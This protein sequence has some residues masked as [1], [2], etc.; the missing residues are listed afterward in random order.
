MKPFKTISLVDR[1]KASSYND[2][3]ARPTTEVAQGEINLKN[4]TEGRSATEIELKVIP[5][6][7]RRN[8][9][10]LK[11]LQKSRPANELPTLGKFTTPSLTSFV[12]PTAGIKFGQTMQLED[13]LKQSAKVENTAHLP[14][15]YLSDV[16][17]NYIKIKPTSIFE[18]TS[19]V[20]VPKFN[21]IANKGGTSISAWQFNSLQNQGVVVT[22]GNYLS[23][24]NIK[25]PT[26]NVLVSQGTFFTN[27]RF[28]SQATISQPITQDAIL[29][30]QG[31]VFS[32]GGY[33]SITVLTEPSINQNQG[34]L[35]P[36]LAISPL[37]VRLAQGLTLDNAGNL[38]SY[39]KP[40][41]PI[42]L[43]NPET[44][45]PT[46][47]Q[48]SFSSLIFEQG[49]VVLV[50]VKFSTTQVDQGTIQLQTSQYLANR[51]KSI[52]LPRIEHGSAFLPVT[53]FQNR[54]FF[55]QTLLKAQGEDWFATNRLNIGESPVT[56]LLTNQLNDAQA[57]ELLRGAITGWRYE[58]TNSRQGAA[59][60]GN[61][62]VVD[63]SIPSVWNADVTSTRPGVVERRVL[64]VRPNAENDQSDFITFQID[65]V[66]GGSIKFKALITSLTDNWSPSWS[67]QNYVG[68]QDTLKVFKGVTRSVSLSFKVVAWSNAT[69][70]FQKLETL[71]KI[72]SVGSP[73]GPG[74]VKGPLI[75]LT[76]GKLFDKVYCA[77]NSLK[78]DFN[79]AEF[80]WD[81][82]KQLPMLAD[83][84]MDVAILTSNNAQMFNAD[85]NRYFNY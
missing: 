70:M 2:I 11:A 77:C 47:Q 43:P 12:L 84:S 81:I 76:V 3:S 79:P 61:V 51:A 30:G 64:G 22:N 45:T 1:L 34:G 46:L 28:I 65:K 66:S 50:N 6:N 68:R 32:N 83:V 13:R 8:E 42:E 5:D 82:K 38:I 73:T 53:D 14:H 27:G 17:T 80:S 39:T 16:Y 36:V 35:A 63:Q 69:T 37:V 58:K 75:K 7:R 15:F 72:T 54:N 24:T 20:E 4:T 49:S 71:A 55:G 10:I 23:V 21:F 41:T 59:P 44:T 40:A 74:Y 25:K 33:T 18:H 57:K 85:T 19:T 48:T 67:D 26:Q 31:A 60:E 29:N 56:G 9:E 52:V 78:F 62:R